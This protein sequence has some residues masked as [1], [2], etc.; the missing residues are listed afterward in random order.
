MLFKYICL[1]IKLQYIRLRCKLSIRRGDLKMAKIKKKTV[2]E[3]L[4]ELIQFYSK[5]ESSDE[6]LRKLIVRNLKD[7]KKRAEGE[8]VHE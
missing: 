2:I 8:K 1:Y 7:V 6:R 4:D 5:A 3:H